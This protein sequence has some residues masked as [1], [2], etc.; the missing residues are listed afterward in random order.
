VSYRSE[1]V[2]SSRRRLPGLIPEGGYHVLAEFCPV[3]ELNLFSPLRPVAVC[4]A[5]EL[6]NCML[7]T[8][9]RRLR[10]LVISCSGPFML[11]LSH[12]NWNDLGSFLHGSVNYCYIPTSSFICKKYQV[13]SLCTYCE[14]LY[15]MMLLDYRRTTR[16][17][18]II[19]ELPNHYCQSPEGSRVC[20]RDPKTFLPC[21]LS[22]H[23]NQ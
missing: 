20:Q 1:L 14:T 7:F 15:T 6:C 22:Y 17:R 19:P 8:F 11:S 13:P 5:L 18:E 2:R 21:L 23:K 12:S 9:R 4:N 16:H 3:S 10:N